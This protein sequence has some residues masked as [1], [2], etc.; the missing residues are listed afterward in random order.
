MILGFD[1]IQPRN[2][3]YIDSIRKRLNDKVAS[4]DIDKLTTI[5]NTE[6]N[7]K[8]FESLKSDL[9]VKAELEENKAWNIAKKWVRARQTIPFKAP[10]LGSIL[11]ALQTSKII[12]SDV[13]KKG[14]QL[15][16]LLTLESGQ[17]VFFKPQRYPR[18]YVTDDIYS[19]ADRHN[20]E[21]IGKVSIKF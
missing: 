20:G 13:I 21:I 6:E 8:Y 14:T 9:V 5:R 3:T 18:D 19:G 2:K 1:E 7:G 15:K 12:K 4:L 10:E 11:H 16:L 17:Q